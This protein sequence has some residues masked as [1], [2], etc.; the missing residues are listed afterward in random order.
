MNECGDVVLL[1]ARF[2]ENHDGGAASVT[3]SSDNLF[4]KGVGVSTV[5]DNA[6][7]GS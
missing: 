4:S 5:T 7:T 1:E 6:S 3:G 2:T